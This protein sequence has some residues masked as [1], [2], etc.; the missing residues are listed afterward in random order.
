MGLVRS[1]NDQL[2]RNRIRME[3]GTQTQDIGC[4]GMS[5]LAFIQGEQERGSHRLRMVDGRLPT[6][7]QQHGVLGAI[8]L[9]VVDEATSGFFHIS[10]CL[11]EGQ[12]KPTQEESDVPRVGLG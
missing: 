12:W 4:Q 9:E 6:S 2:F 11:I 3:K 7:C 1:L 5:L 8:A 10:S